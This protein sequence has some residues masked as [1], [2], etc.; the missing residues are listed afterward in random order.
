[1]STDRPTRA[2][3][4]SATTERL[5][6]TAQA[7]FAA[8]GFAA[9]SLD[10]VAAEAGVTRGALHHHFTNKAGLLEA[11][12]RRIDAEIGDEL[13]PVYEAHSDPWAG[14]RA[15]FHAYL[16]AV[17]Q[18]SRL[19]ILFQDAPAVLGMKSVDILLESGL[20]EVMLML[21]GLAS[22][23]RIRAPDAEA[24]ALVLNSTAVTLAFW[25]AEDAKDVD[26]LKR[27]HA[28]LAALFDGITAPETALGQR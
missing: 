7:A 19:R 9:V 13:Q 8:R 22:K 14:F 16:D 4:A 23:G 12:L 24:L 18:P 15:V 10:A 2:E 28:T 26:R 21:Q 20:S 11:V 5:L 17:L 25:V 27:A 1:M 3:T 6:R